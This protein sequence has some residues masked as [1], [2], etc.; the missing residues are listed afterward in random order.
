MSAVDVVPGIAPGTAHRSSAVR[1]ARVPVRCAE[2]IRALVE[3]HLHF[4]MLVAGEYR[5]SATPFDDLLAEGCVGLVE[6]AHRFD[7]AHNVK[8]LTYASW[9]IRKRIL[10]FLAREGKPV[11]MTRYARDRRRALR[12]AQEALRGTLGREPS[13]AEIALAT[14]IDAAEVERAL[15]PPRMVSIDQPGD[16]GRESLAETIADPR[17][18]APADAIDARVLAEQVR[19]EVL[20]LPPRERI[21]V[22]S[23]FGLDG[24]EARTFQ[25]LGDS[26]GISRERVRQLEGDALARLR[27]RLRVRH[28]RRNLPAVE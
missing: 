28:L 6:A 2:D 7:C 3:P 4:V 9:W 19:R 10:D 26:L 5:S 11:H 20:L 15:R 13:H 8:F 27:R 23:R 1:T 22:E 24:G 21:I 12:L 16:D 17:G 18:T 14:G 25:E